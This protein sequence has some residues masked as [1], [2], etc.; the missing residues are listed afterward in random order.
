MAEELRCSERLKRY[1]RG[2][3]TAREVSELRRFTEETLILI[4]EVPA[5]S[6]VL[7]G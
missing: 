6:V 3:K 7:C 2:N 4:F 5:Y 1:G